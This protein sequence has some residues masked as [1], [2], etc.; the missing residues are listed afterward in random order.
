MIFLNKKIAKKTIFPDQKWLKIFLSKKIFSRPKM[1]KEKKNLKE[2]KKPWWNQDLTPKKNSL[3]VF[4]FSRGCEVLVFWV[5]KD[6]KTVNLFF[7]LL[8]WFESKLMRQM[9]PSQW[10]ASC[11][12]RKSWFRTNLSNR[13][14]E[15]TNQQEYKPNKKKVTSKT[16]LGDSSLPAIHQQCASEASRSDTQMTIVSAEYGCTNEFSL[17]AKTLSGTHLVKQDVSV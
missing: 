14:S 12:H 8:V 2:Q 9:H 11:Q 16:E 13:K 5:N 17:H 15:Q 7:V 3:T 10:S 6:S 1:T 4:A